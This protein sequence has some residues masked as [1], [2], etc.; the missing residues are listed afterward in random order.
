MVNHWQLFI[1]LEFE[2]EF[3]C[4]FT[5]DLSR[6]ILVNASCNGCC[7]FS[8]LFIRINDIRSI[9]SDAVVIIIV[10]CV[11]VDA[12]FS[13]HGCYCFQ[14]QFYIC[15][16]PIVF[17]FNRSIA[18]YLRAHKHLHASKQYQT[19][20]RRWSL[21]WN[22]GILCADSLPLQTFGSLDLLSNLP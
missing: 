7:R 10:C 21:A 18:K 14:N 8:L 9:Y 1:S 3:V 17:H 11:V 16:Y 19:Y 2:F 15:I 4:H 22:M 5:V 12:V 20:L 6:R 13:W